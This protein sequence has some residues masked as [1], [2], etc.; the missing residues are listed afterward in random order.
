MKRILTVALVSAICYHAISQNK[1]LTIED[2]LVKNRTTLATENLKQLQFLY[3]TDDYVYLKKE[4][5]T[6]YWVKGNFKT[7]Q[8]KTFLTLAE[9]NAKMKTAD[10]DTF[11][12]MPEIKFN[13]SLNWL[14]VNKG[15]KI[16]YNPASQLASAV[17]DKAIAAK[18]NVEESNAGLVAYL[19]NKNLF[20]K[21]GSQ[22]NQITTDG[23][24]DIVYAS[25]VHRDEFGISKGTFW[26]NGGHQLAYYRMDQ[27]MVA[28]YPIIDWTTHPA[29][30][31]NIKYPMAGDKSHQVTVWVHNADNNKTVQLQT[32]EPAGQYLTNIAWSPDDKF[33]F[34]AV[35]NPEQN[36]MK[37]N[38]Y[39]ASN[40]VFVKTL[41]IETDDKY[42]EPLVPVLFVK[43]NPNQFI[44]QSNRSG[45]NHLYLYNIDGS[46]IRQ[47][48]RGDWE[49]QEVKG[50]DEK[51]EKLFYMSNQIL[52]I[53]KDLFSI[54]IATGKI[55]QLTNGNGIHTTQISSEGKYILDNE[56]N[57]TSARILRLT[58]TATGK[59]G[60]LLQANNPLADFALGNMEISTIPN[61]TGIPLYSR[62]FKPVG[63]D[64]TKKYPVIVY[65]YG[66]PHNQLINAGFNGGAS[67]YW[68]QYMAERGYIVFSI[69]VRGSDSRGKAFEQAIFRHAGQAQMED[70]MAGVNYL[71]SLPFVDKS[72]MGLFGWSY[73]GFLTIDFM[74]NH[75][76]IFKAATAGGPVV[77]WSYYEIMYGERYMDTPQENPEGYAATDLTKQVDKLKGKLLIIHGL[78]DPVVVQQ[79]SVRFVRAAI[80]KNIQ[81]DYMIYPGHEHNVLGKDRAHLYQKVTDYF[82]QWLK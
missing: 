25:S 22:T 17:V 42:V 34:I 78:Q 73:G 55:K 49:V 79:H 26:S 40:G 41:F 6:E 27:S 38:Q 20:V 12:A 48:T 76:G 80:D 19:D 30:V 36:H 28:G 70:M 37:L 57:A 71:Q 16:S 29:K 46:L 8:P 47:L 63:F 72:K 69:D 58:E 52:P 11:S 24:S 3:G 5:S 15:V 44:W 1:L 50:F 54:N 77:D 2:A 62:L 51:G 14:I 32:G 31:T 61:N 68:F 10:M 53:V 13:K 39:N 56:S 75:P 65:W 60:I 74:L 59:S 7:K 33:I 66:G 9:L 4:G 21:D 43:N 81:V 35:L 45:F 18:E 67:D 64:S 82:E 23:S